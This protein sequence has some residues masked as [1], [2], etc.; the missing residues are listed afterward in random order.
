MSEFMQNC[1][2]PI[3]FEGFQ[4]TRMPRDIAVFFDDFI[5]ASWSTTA[6][7]NIWN[8]TL[9]A[10]LTTA[11]VLD[12]TDD[13]EDEA[14]GVLNLIT[15]GTVDDGINLQVNGHAFHMADGYP[16][17]FETRINIGDVSN[18]DGFIGLAVT[19]PEIFTG[20]VSDRVGFEL[21]AGTLSAISE[22]TTVQKTV[23]AG[24]TET[25][26]DWIRLA[27][28]WDGDDKL[29]FTVDTDD[30]GVFD[31]VT[32]LKASTTADYVVQDMM[33]TPTIEFITGAT[34]TAERMY[35][36]YVLCMQ[37]RFSE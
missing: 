22:N 2:I 8:Q 26:D 6:D 17:Y 33:M 14:G 23:N 29:V 11:A 16:L 37:Q 31:Y 10:Q 19:D 35:V 12:G 3:D 13:A 4:N 7:A 9:I 20:G 15:E 34:A 25:D 27:F 1:G 36:D 24:I 18:V 21:S 5:G 32:T 30:D 28:F